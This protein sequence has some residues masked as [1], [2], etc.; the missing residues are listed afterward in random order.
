MSICY[1]SV[2]YL[3]L[4]K[5]KGRKGREWRKR[6]RSESTIK[7]EGH[8]NGSDDEWKKGKRRRRRRGEEGRHN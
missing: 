3:T 2:I 6:G 8:M 4:K 7:R 1:K 5:H